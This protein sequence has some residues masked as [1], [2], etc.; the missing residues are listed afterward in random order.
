MCIRD[1]ETV[2]EE[3]EPV[4]RMPKPP[5]FAREPVKEETV[6]A[7]AQNRQNRDTEHTFLDVKLEP[8]THQFLDGAG[9]VSY[10]HLKIMIS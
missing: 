6:A 9:A 1:R 4:V 8:Y 7:P 3:Q 2:Q 10:T 5:V